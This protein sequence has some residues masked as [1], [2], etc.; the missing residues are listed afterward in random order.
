MPAESRT[1]I[2]RSNAYPSIIARS[3]YGTIG[4]G[5]ERARRHEERESLGARDV[6]SAQPALPVLLARG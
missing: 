1:V 4:S 2:A 6:G 3:R 5:G